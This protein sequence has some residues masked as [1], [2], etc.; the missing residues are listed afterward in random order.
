[1][2]FAKNRAA[3]I[4]LPL[5][6]FWPIVFA[7]IVGAVVLMIGTAGLLELSNE[8]RPRNALIPFPLTHLWFLYVL[9]ILYVA[10]IAVRSAVAAKDRAGTL[11]THIDTMVAWLVRTPLVGPVV[12]GAPVCVL[13]IANPGWMSLTGIPTPDSSL[14]PNLTAMVGYGTA[15]GLGWLLHRNYDAMFAWGRQW[16]F[17]LPLAL[18]LT[19]MC[20]A[21]HGAAMP[22]KII[23]LGP[24]KIQFAICYALAIWC[25]TFAFIGLALRFLDSESPTRRYIADASY[26]MYIV[27]LPLVM[28]L[29]A[30]I[31]HVPA[32]WWLKYAGLMTVT[33]AILFAS[34]QLFVRNTFIGRLL[35]G[36]LPGEKQ[37]LQMRSRAAA[38]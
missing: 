21:I 8:V 16:G 25:W 29:Q 10:A 22:P 24:E 35:N 4:A 2:G 19:T 12:L 20:L 30:I 38:Q 37:T 15:F 13:F 11:R 31:A 5:V 7:G 6:I 17:Y 34:Y 26:W 3:R 14:D 9:L 1:V 27:H 32:P 36:P 18:A 33:F 28:A 23:P